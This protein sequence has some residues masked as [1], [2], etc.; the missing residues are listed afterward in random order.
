MRLPLWPALAL[1]RDQQEAREPDF[2]RV[3]RDQ[4]ELVGGVA[5]PVAKKVDG[6]ARELRLLQ[7]QPIEIGAR[8]RVRGHGR[9]RHRGR[10]AWLSVEHR[11]LADDF[12]GS[13][14]P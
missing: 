5:Q 2:D 7:Q 8:Q 10:R 11:D 12:A 6:V 3:K 14:P 1:E 4:F 9:E 13:S